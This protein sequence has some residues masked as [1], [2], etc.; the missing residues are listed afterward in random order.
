MDKG[1]VFKFGGKVKGGL[2]TKV[3]SRGRTPPASIFHWC[4]SLSLADLLGDCAPDQHETTLPQGCTLDNRTTVTVGA[5][6]REKC[7]CNEDLLQGPGTSVCCCRA[8][9]QEELTAA[10]VCPLPGMVPR[11]PNATRCR[12]N[13]CD[14]LEVTIVLTVVAAGSKVPIPAARVFRMETNSDMTMLGISNNF[15]VFRFR[16]VVGVGSVMLQVQASGYLAQTVPSLELVPTSLMVQREVVLLPG[17]NIEVGLGG[18]PLVLRLGSMLSVSAPPRSF[19]TQDG[20]VYEDMIRFMGN[21]VEVGDEAAREAIPQTSFVF[22]DPA[23]GQ[24]Q[25]FGMLV[26][27]ILIFV[28]GSGRPLTNPNGV[29]VSV[30]VM[31][32]EEEDMDVVLLTHDPEAGVFVKTTE[33]TPVEPLRRKRQNTSPVIFL[34]TG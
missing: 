32:D 34:G 6:S 28:D 15:G 21:V 29:Q 9:Q 14:D 5:C 31:A 10:I 7:L 25:N 4:L 16:E 17:L 24:E 13:T 2:R 20:E 19:R 1:W 33:L 23:T 26:G 30:S 12:C 22:T 3:G 11:I 8:S 27:M 18:A